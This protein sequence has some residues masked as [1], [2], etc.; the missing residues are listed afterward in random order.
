MHQQIRRF[1][2]PVAMATTLACATVGMTTAAPRQTT[3]G[4]DPGFAM[5]TALQDAGPHP[6]LSEHARVLGRLTIEIA[7]IRIDFTLLARL[8]RIDDPGTWDVDYLDITKDGKQIRRTG[9]LRVGWLMDGRAIEDLRSPRS[10]R[11]VAARC[12]G[13]ASYSRAGT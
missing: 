2:L 6:S 8:G 5:S 13:I 11:D 12:E 7:H 1:A 3:P 9:E 4:T 10:R